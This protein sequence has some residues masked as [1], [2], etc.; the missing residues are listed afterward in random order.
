MDVNQGRRTLTPAE[1]EHLVRLYDGNLA[2][3]DRE[4]GEL[5]RALEARG[6]WDKTI[7]IIAAD[8]GEALL[9]HGWIGHNVQLFEESA[10]VPLIVRFPARGGRGG[11]AGGALWPTCSTSGPPSRTCS[12][13]SARAARTARSPAAACCR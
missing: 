3:A 8:H 2:Y 9:D 7:V 11:P 5:R 1:A 10:R 4:V 6:L 13:S 12:A